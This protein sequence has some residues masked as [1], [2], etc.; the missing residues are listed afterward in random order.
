MQLDRRTFMAAS[1]AAAFALSTAS[2][3]AA[4]VVARGNRYGLQKQFVDRRFG[5]FL[6][7]NMGTFPY[8]EGVDRTNGVGPPDSGTVEIPPAMIQ[9]VK[10]QLTELLTQYGEVPLLIFDGWAWHWSFNHQS[11]PFA[12]I[13]DH[14]TRLQPNCLVI[15]LNGLTV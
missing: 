7:F 2:P 5:V 11:I 14:V 3:A 15:D 10:D 4:S 1:G 13:R 9:F 12:E 8:A 6:P